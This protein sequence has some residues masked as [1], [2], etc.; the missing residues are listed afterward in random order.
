MTRR[1][2]R[3]KVE[4]SNQ[5][6]LHV[7]NQRLIKHPI[8]VDVCF[9]AS[10]LKLR[11]WENLSSVIKSTVS[12]FFDTRVSKYETDP[13]SFFQHCLD[14]SVELI[15]E[16][17]DTFRNDVSRLDWLRFFNREAQQQCILETIIPS[18]EQMFEGENGPEALISSVLV[19]L[20]PTITQRVSEYI[21]LFI[22]HGPSE[23]VSDNLMLNCFAEE[24]Y[25]D[26]IVR[27][28]SDDLIEFLTCPIEKARIKAA[29][30]IKAE[31]V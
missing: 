2:K 9:L 21:S 7:L 8:S 15:P 20:R 28:P 10:Q 26:Y 23:K 27:L 31:C 25:E 4:I 12:Q 30:K 16:M 11:T 1:A 5:H 14:R 19:S 17:K 3:T 29:N 24:Y 6:I 22:L 13:E 18:F